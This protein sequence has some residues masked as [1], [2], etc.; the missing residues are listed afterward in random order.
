MV[1]ETSGKI[2]Y[3]VVQG[4]A[5]GPHPINE[6]QTR[7]QHG[8]LN[9][10]DL[11]FRPGLSRWV[12]IAECEEFERR[13]PPITQTAGKPDIPT[14]HSVEGWILLVKHVG[15]D[16][17]ENYLQSGPYTTE[18]V[19]EKLARGEIKYD[20]HVWQKGLE[21]WNKLGTTEDFER[22]RPNDY[23][24]GPKPE[25]GAEEKTLPGVEIKMTEDTAKFSPKPEESVAPTT[26]PSLFKRRRLVIAASG[27]ILGM[28]L[29]YAGIQAYEQSLEQT[30]PKTLPPR[31]VASLGSVAQAPLPKSE[32]PVHPEVQNP[33]PVAKSLKI[34]G[35]KLAGPKPLL[36]FETNLPGGSAID[37]EISA[38]PGAIL[39]YPSFSLKKK[40]PVIAGQMPS[41][42][43][44]NDHLAPGE[45]KTT[46]QA[47]GLTAQTKLV[48]GTQDAA[49]KKRLA[50]FK[51]T[52]AK[53]SQR[54][55]TQ[56][57]G[58]VKFIASSY[59]H[60]NAQYKKMRLPASSA[61]SK[62]K[63]EQWYK[64]WHAQQ[65]KQ[66]KALVGVTERS[67]NS[68]V[69]PDELLRLKELNRD[70][71]DM[72]RNLNLSVKTGRQIA[73]T[74]VNEEQFK[75]KLSALQKDLKHLGGLKK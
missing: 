53:L 40:I 41:V 14:H 16:G 6:L 22:R 54:E 59:T 71:A 45:Y 11:V 19:R 56:L 67:R 26:N 37:L 48:I 31:V 72:S 5:D 7:L 52:V 51:K 46:A 74:Q 35:I 42:D 27:A 38:T 64:T 75:N 15:A 13:T 68:Y 20:D 34:V 61:V 63:W 29:A 49:F 69:H 28:A 21:T 8:R 10:S 57:N 2:W 58:G 24:K 50:I 36:M 43:L 47:M 9:Y 66:A 33:P 44:T 23:A 65:E 60:M 55:R 32:A 25:M 30:Q 17:L 4:K 73:S 18:Q 62:K 3:V 1:T 70:L 12:P 39:K